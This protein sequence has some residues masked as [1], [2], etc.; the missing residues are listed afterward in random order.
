M[1][2]GG[3]PN[4]FPQQVDLTNVPPGQRAAVLGAAWQDY[5]DVYHQWPNTWVTVGDIIYLGGYGRP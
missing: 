5:Y 2:N 1:S 4:K 3:P